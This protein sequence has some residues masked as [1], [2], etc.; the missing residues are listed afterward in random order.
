MLHGLKEA[1]SSSLEGK[2]VQKNIVCLVFRMEIVKLVSALLPTE[3]SNM[4]QL[5]HS[6]IIAARE[7]KNNTPH[8]NNMHRKT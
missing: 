3:H 2:Q 4:S 1:L 7:V 5:H 8:Q 6:D